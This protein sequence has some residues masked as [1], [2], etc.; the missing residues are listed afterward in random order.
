MHTGTPTKRQTTVVPAFASFIPSTTTT[1]TTPISSCSTYHHYFLLARGQI[2]LQCQAR[3]SLALGGWFFPGSVGGPSDDDIV[4]KILVA[5]SK[6]T[7]TD[8]AHARQDN[9]ALRQI[10]VDHSHR[11]VHIGVVFGQKFQAGL[12]GHNGH[13]VDLWNSPLFQNRNDGIGCCRASDHG[14]QNVGHVRGALTP[15]QPIEVL[16]GSNVDTGC[17]VH[18][19]VVNGRIGQQFQHGIR[20]AQAAAENRHQSHLVQEAKAAVRVAEIFVVG[21]RFLSQG[22]RHPYIRLDL[23]VF[24]R[25]VSQVVRDFS[26]NASKGSGRCLGGS[27]HGDLVGEHGVRSHGDVGGELGL[28]GAFGI[29]HTVGFGGCGRNRRGGGS[30]WTHGESTGTEMLACRKIIWK[31]RNEEIMT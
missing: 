29:D 18:A 14:I 6:Q 3:R 21:F 28:A 12:A 1:T 20:H 2:H 31:F 4:L 24:G 7:I 26:E 11:H 5:G 15:G 17:A 13:D 27:Q 22:D 23:E 9:P 25:L 30:G 19:N 8:V 10:G 16:H